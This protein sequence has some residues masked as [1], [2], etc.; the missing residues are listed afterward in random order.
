[1]L[2]LT[3]IGAETGPTSWVAMLH[4]LYGRGR[5]WQ[6]VAKVLGA[7]RPDWGSL[8]IDLRLHGE[9]LGFEPPHTLARAAEDVCVTLTELAQD[10]E[11][12]SVSAVLGHS[13][14]GKVALALATSLAGRLSQIWVID[15]TPDARAPSGSAWDMLAHVRA[16]PATFATRPEAIAA[17]EGRG[18]A[19]GVATWMAT[20]LRFREGR[21]R[22]ALD[23]DGLEALARSFFATD[24]W[25][26]VE[27][28]PGSVEIHFV[29][30]EE[31]HALSEEACARITRAHD[32]NGRVHLH[33]VAGGHWLNADNPE[34]IIALLAEHLGRG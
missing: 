19:T 31:S 3:R 4:G 26:I 34:A 10:A 7:R 23:F 33:R 24:L 22:W 28:P 5:N 25:P 6:S 8:L 9:S 11:P 21:F 17:L 27:Q 1:M 13:L 2:Q 18:L 30:A 20:N 12:V 16:L 29:K 32:A 14:G 15:S